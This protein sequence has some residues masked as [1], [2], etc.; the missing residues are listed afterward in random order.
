VRSRTFDAVLAVTVPGL[1][2][3]ASEPPDDQSRAL[4]DNHALGH[5]SHG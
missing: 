1:V 5:D 3:A 2:A 4:L